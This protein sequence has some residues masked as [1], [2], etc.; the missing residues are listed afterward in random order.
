MRKFLEA[1]G[2]LAVAGAAA[3]GLVYY[4]QKKG[5]LSVEVNYDDEEGNAVS[6]QFD[7]I[8]DT[9]AANVG[10]KA[11]KAYV[12]VSKKVTDTAKGI[13]DNLD[14]GLDGLSFEK[15]DGITL[16]INSDEPSDEEL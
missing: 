5:V 3:T 15:K 16:P 13:K 11:K 8:V 6:R 4:L 7:E 10:E 1:V 9:V 14:A 2:T 12:D